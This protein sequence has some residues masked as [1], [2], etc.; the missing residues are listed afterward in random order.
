MLTRAR[1]GGY[2]IASSEHRPLSLVADPTQRR[3][4]HGDDAPHIV[5][6][7]GLVERDTNVVGF[8][9]TEVH[10]R[11]DYVATN[12]REPRWRIQAHRYRI[13]E[14][15]IDRRDPEPLEVLRQHDGQSMHPP[16][17]L[18]EAVGPVIDGIEARDVGQE[19]LSGTDVRRG[20]LAA[21]MLFPRLERHP[22]GA[23]AVCVD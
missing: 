23:L 19:G 20:L 2:S 6:C 22:V 1:A 10:A 21:N 11:P 9:Q 8:A 7:G 14:H 17:N 3:C 5:E 13:E 4:Q 15:R 16:G 18:L 12:R